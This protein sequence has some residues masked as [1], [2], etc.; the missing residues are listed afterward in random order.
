[1]RHV[2]DVNQPVGD[3]LC[4]NVD[5]SMI[6]AEI[7]LALIL[8]FIDFNEWLFAAVTVVVGV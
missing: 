7:S 3:V 5:I 2:S 4:K 8:C 1:M 6:G